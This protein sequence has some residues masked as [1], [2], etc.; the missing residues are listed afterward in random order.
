MPRILEAPIALYGIAQ[1]WG[2]LGMIAPML[3]IKTGVSFRHE[4]KARE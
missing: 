4:C 2:E 3:F 1:L